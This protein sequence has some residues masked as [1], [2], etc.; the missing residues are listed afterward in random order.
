MHGGR[1][2]EV[3][4]FPGCEILVPCPGIKPTPLAQSP[5][6]W[7]RQG[8]PSIYLLIGTDITFISWHGFFFFY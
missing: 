5:N 6:H 8:I 4:Q 7:D 1:E 2:K 3:P